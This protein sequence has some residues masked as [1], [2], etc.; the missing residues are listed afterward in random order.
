M[1]IMVTDKN[2]YPVL[3]TVG[4]LVKTIHALLLLGV[5]FL[6]RFI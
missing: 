3:N 6:G 2:D 5:S 4:V 1:S